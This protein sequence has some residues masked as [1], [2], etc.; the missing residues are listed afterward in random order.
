M[1]LKLYQHPLASYCHKAIMAFYENATPFEPIF[2]DLGDE[3]SRAAFVELWPMAKFPVLHDTARDVLVPES[4]IIIEYLAQHYPGPTKL[5]LDE[6]DLARETR[7]KDRFYDLYVQEPM[8]KAIGDRLRPEGQKDPFGV[9]QAKKTLETAYAFIDAEMRDKTWAM[10]DVFTWPTARRRPRS[11]TPT[12]SSR[13]RGLTR[14]SPHTG[15]V[16]SPARPT[17]ARCARRSR[18]YTSYRSESRRRRPSSGVR[19]SRRPDVVADRL[20]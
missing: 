10:G 3:T 5:V 15:S 20:R 19:D 8:Q 16:S 17:R 9:A 1:S 4:T 14:T 2:V 7:Q 18:T 12:R 13:S 6:P 11:S